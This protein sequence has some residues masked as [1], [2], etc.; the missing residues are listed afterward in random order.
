M[1]I[2]AWAGLGA[3]TATAKAKTAKIGKALI[4]PVAFIAIPLSKNEEIDCTHLRYNLAENSE[5]PK[6]KNS[7]F[8]M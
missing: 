4:N 1:P 8:R 7:R 6:K 3:D 5:H 2:R